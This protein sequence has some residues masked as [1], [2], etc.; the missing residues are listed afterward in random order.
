MEWNEERFGS[1]GGRDLL[2]LWCGRKKV[3]EMREAVRKW[4]L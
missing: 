4:L 2:M 1:W 3:C